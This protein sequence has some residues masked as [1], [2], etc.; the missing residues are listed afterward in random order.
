MKIDVKQLRIGT[1]L[2]RPGQEDGF[3]V[4]I[5]TLDRLSHETRDEKYMELTDKV[6]K[7]FGFAVYDSGANN[8]E[9]KH[10]VFPFL[11]IKSISTLSYLQNN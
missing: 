7:R 11:L 1:L 4:D 3:F 5:N 9:A 6:M 2:K 8:L 10:P